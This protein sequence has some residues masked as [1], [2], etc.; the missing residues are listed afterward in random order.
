MKK[1]IVMILAMGAVCFT[2]CETAETIIA[3]MDT[4]VPD[5][6]IVNDSI[7]VDFGTSSSMDITIS[8]PSGIRRIDITYGAWSIVEVIDFSV[9]DDYSTS[10]DYTINFDVPADSAKSWF[11]QVKTGYYHNG[12]EYQYTEYFHKIEIKATDKY[13][14]ERKSNACVR[15]R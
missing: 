5:V 2:S 8:D 13:L 9:E 12:T 10:Y 15:V 1:Y 4:L 3:D 14:N 7:D 11:S 6:V